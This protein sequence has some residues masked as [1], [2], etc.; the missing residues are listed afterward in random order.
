MDRN[1]LRKLIVGPIATVPTPFDDDYEVDYGRMYE[2][3]QQW[4]DEGIVAGKGVIKIAAA[5]GEGP[6][7][8]DDEWPYLLRTTVQAADGKAAI[9]CGLHYKDTKRTVEDAKRAQDMGAIGLQI[10]PPIFNMPSQGDLLDYFGEISDAIDIGIMVYCTHWMPGGRVEVDTILRMADIPQVAAIKWSTPDDI[11]FEEM[12][13]FSS[14][15]SVIDNSSMPSENHRLGG[16]GYINVTYESYPQHDNKIWEL[17]ESGKY[18]EATALFDSVNEPLREFDEKLSGRSG[19]QA[20]LKKGLMALMGRPVGSSRPPS[21]PMT[22]EEMEGLRKV[23]LDLGW[24]V[25]SSS[26]EAAAAAAGD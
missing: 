23:L 14:T 15:F 25:K 26:R 1:E 21:K 18:D 24:P 6:M 10:C 5:M 12:E 4:V 11:A 22:A 2:L 8:S 16:R 20:R 9:V 19:G 3:T 17:L 7:L 13:K